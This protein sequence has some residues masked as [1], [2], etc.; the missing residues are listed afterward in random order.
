M[1]EG[2]LR[3]SRIAAFWS[4]EAG[5]V[6]PVY[7]GGFSPEPTVSLMISILR[8]RGETTGCLITLRRFGQEAAAAA[9]LSPASLLPPPG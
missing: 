9:G 1:A 2:S 3:I 7:G 4:R 8:I 6:T 5:K